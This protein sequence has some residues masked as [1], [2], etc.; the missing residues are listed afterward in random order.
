MIAMLKKMLVREGLFTGA[1]P[2]EGFLGTPKLHKEG[3]FARVCAK[4]PRFNT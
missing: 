3:N 2:G 4:V 1:D